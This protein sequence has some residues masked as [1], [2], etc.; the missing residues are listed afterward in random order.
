[1]K[2]NDENKNS[3]GGVE[4]DD[5]MLDSVAG[6]LV[7]LVNPSSSRLGGSKGDLTH[8]FDGTVCPQCGSKQMVIAKAYNFPDRYDVNCNACGTRVGN[9]VSCNAISTK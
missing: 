6:G 5:D 8:F 3:S 9:K 7:Q 1:M 2:S 4:L